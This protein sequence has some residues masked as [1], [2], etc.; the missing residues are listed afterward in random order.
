MM[1]HLGEAFSKEVSPRYFF[2]LE[3][4]TNERSG[5]MLRR[6]SRRFEGI[7]VFP[8]QAQVRLREVRTHGVTACK[9]LTT[10]GEREIF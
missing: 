2:F 1:E 4:F 5:K 10:A 8:Q 3:I 9:F 6:R 7:G